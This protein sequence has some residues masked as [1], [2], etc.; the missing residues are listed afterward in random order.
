MLEELEK[1]KK[2]WEFLGVRCEMSEMIGKM[3]IKK[4][5]KKTESPNFLSL[6]LNNTDLI[7]IDI[8]NIGNS[9][10]NFHL[11]LEEKNIKINQFFV[12][13]TLHKGYHLFFRSPIKKNQ[14][15]IYGRDLG[16]IKYDIL[17]FGRVFTSPSKYGNLNYSF[18]NKGPFEID[19][20][21]EIPDFNNSLFNILTEIQG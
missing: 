15:N 3:G 5:H 6:Y 21:N 7:C 10:N 2:R 16:G 19:D 12:E 1:F 13:S 9:V 17:F 4:F 11:L 18:I 14:K 20:L 8:D